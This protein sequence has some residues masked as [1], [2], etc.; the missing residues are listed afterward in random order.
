M[1]LTSENVTA[2]G[3]AHEIGVVERYNLSLVVARPAGPA[4]KPERTAGIG[5]ANHDENLA[6]AG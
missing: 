2:P 3:R 4:G 1:P 6:T 5:A